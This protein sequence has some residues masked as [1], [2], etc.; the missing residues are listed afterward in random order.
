MVASKK[1][2]CSTSFDLKDIVE[3]VEQMKLDDDG[4]AHNVSS[5]SSKRQNYY[6]VKGTIGMKMRK[7]SSKCGICG[8]VG[9]WYRD[10]PSCLA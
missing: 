8:E 7:S 6:E 1:S 5:L 2:Q 3:I 4:N 9:H 10:K